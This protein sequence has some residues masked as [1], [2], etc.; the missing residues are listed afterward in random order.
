MVF[1]GAKLSSIPTGHVVGRPFLAQVR[2]LAVEAEW[3]ASHHPLLPIVSLPP[4][5]GVGS[6]PDGEMLVATIPPVS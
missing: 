1:A 4:K 2:G 6:I 3:P 5:V